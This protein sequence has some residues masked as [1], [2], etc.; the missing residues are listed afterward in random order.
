MLEMRIFSAMAV[1]L[2]AS[3]LSGAELHGG[4]PDDRA[5]PPAEKVT[6]DIPD[7]P[8]VSASLVPDGFVS[9]PSF[10]KTGSGVGVDTLDIGDGYL[11]LVLFDDY[12][13]RY[14]KNMKKVL[15]YL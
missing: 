5:L 10:F 6:V 11:Q 14:I 9:E 1:C 3:V 13:W 12:S 8:P 7:I 2:A 4:T 15:P